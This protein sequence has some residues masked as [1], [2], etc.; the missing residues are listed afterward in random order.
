[1]VDSERMHG[2]LIIVL[3]NKIGGADVYG[4][5]AGAL[6]KGDI[7]AGGGSEMLLPPRFDG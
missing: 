1:M 3:G 5:A 6:E 7:G 4:G 2:E